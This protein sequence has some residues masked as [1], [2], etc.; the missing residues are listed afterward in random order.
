MSGGYVDFNATANDD[1]AYI[2]WARGELRKAGIDY[3]QSSL[4]G[5]GFN[6]SWVI[7]QAIQI[8]GEL[9]GRLNRANFI[10]ALRTMDMTEPTLLT[11][12]KFNMNGNA[13]A[14]PTEGSDISRWDATQQAW[15]VEDIIDISGST[16]SCAWVA[17]QAACT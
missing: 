12:T 14:Y 7:M 16:K 1:D 5:S 9:D 6:T 8:A 13:D 3:L 4:Y 17:A 15:V 2:S 11:G 10:L